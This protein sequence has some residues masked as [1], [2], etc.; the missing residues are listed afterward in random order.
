MA[1][2]G[3]PGVGLG[4]QPLPTPSPSGLAWGPEASH[5]QLPQEKECFVCSV[6]VRQ[7]LP[8]CRQSL[9]LLDKMTEPF[10]PSPP[11][12]CPSSPCEGAFVRSAPSH[13]GRSQVPPRTV[14]SPIAANWMEEAI[15]ALVQASCQRTACVVFAA[16]GE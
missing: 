5:A 7:P 4:R 3:C 10:P 2:C 14:L 1:G 15:S 16:H 8:T 13:R 9:P 6:C 11:T 12:P